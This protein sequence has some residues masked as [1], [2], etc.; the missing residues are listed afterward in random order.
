VTVKVFVAQGYLP[1]QARNGSFNCYLKLIDANKNAYDVGP[2]AGDNTLR[3][4]QGTT[5]VGFINGPLPP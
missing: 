2:N 4:Q 1:E 3:P 5:F